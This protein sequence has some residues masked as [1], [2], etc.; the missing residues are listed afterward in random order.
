MGKNT[1]D[2]KKFDSAKE[3]QEAL[4]SNPRPVVVD[5]WASWCAPCRFIEPTLIELSREYNGK[6]DLWKIDA[7]DH[8]H[9]LAAMGV[10]GIPTL[11][12]FY[13]GSEMQRKVG[14]TDKPGLD[15]LFQAALSGEVHGSPAA[16]DRRIRVIFGVAFFIM[17]M[18]GTFDPLVRVLIL[19]LS[20]VLFLSAYYDRLPFWETLYQKLTRRNRKP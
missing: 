11:V 2:H 6:V 16:A 5:F 13:N 17:G 7:D 8:P 18:I 3:F 19:L 12:A 15:N 1:F 9:L 10:R 4:R 14:A 20:G